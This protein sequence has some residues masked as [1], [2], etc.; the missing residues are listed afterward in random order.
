MT[1]DSQSESGGVASSTAWLDR[2]AQLDALIE[3]LTNERAELETAASRIE[4]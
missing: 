3:P 2:I 1:S 4:V